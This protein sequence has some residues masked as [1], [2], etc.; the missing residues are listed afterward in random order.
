MLWASY[1]ISCPR[2]QSEHCR[3]SGMKLQAPSSVVNP[4]SGSKHH[5]NPQQLGNRVILM[6][7]ELSKSVATTMVNHMNDRN[8]KI[9]RQHL[10]ATSY[11]SGSS[12][13][14]KRG[15]GYRRGGEGN[16]RSR[17]K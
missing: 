2:L 1:N 15:D 5:V 6:R 16:S 11:I 4:S 13:G 14:K 10:E 7:A 3:Q 9:L 17:Y 8:M 12:E